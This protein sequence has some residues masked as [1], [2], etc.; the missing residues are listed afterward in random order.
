MMKVYLYAILALLTLA[1]SAK[2]NWQEWWT[3]DGISGPSY[4]GVINPAWTMCNRGRQQSPINVDPDLLVYDE[5]LDDH[6]FQVDKQPMSG[7][8]LNSG[9]S[10]VF[11]VDS[12][13]AAKMP[14]N[15][16]GGPLSYR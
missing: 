11:T 3:Y 5:G 2:A 14:V 12:D 6:L 16:T 9:Q 7:N 1:R 15:I 4:W 8:L 10:L 13:R